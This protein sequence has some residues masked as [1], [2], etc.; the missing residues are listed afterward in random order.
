MLF[1]LQQYFLVFGK[2]VSPKSL[3]VLATASIFH[4]QDSI[5]MSIAS[6]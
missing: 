6:H 3:P 1:S 4:L 2:S 5:K